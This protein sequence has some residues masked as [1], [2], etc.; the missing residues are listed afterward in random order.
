[1]SLA[2]LNNKTASRRSYLKVQRG[3][4]PRA[5]PPFFLQS[6]KYN[7]D[8]QTFCCHLLEILPQRLIFAIHEASLLT[9]SEQGFVGVE[10]KSAG[11]VDACVWIFDGSE[12]RV[13]YNTE[14]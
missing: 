10:N 11:H 4:A 3:Q 7:C 13:L 2:S 6:Y 8:L 1:M 14:G 9:T 12:V 5:H